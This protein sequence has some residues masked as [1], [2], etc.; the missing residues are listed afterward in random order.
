MPRG[1]ARG[2][3]DEQEVAFAVVREQHRHRPPC[4]PLLPRVVRRHRLCDAGGGA[5]C[6]VGHEAAPAE[7]SH[8]VHRA[9]GG[10]DGAQGR[11]GDPS[12]VLSE[13]VADSARG[14]SRRRRADLRARLAE[15]VKHLARGCDRGAPDGADRRAQSRLRALKVVAE[16]F[17]GGG[18]CARGCDADAER[19]VGGDSLRRPRDR[20]D[21]LDG[22]L[23][24]AAARPR[25]EGG[26]DAPPQDDDVRRVDAVRRARL[27]SARGGLLVG[28]GELDVG[29]EV[30]VE[31]GG[32]VA[33][34]H[35]EGELEAV[36]D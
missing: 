13:P 5:L 11:G 1:R 6:D 2:G 8:V 35:I 25:G 32:H 17:G 16:P 18:P 22:R 31:G 19:D 14:D 21:A 12:G 34:K 9:D 28:V 33:A 15:R 7:R 10:A 23:E 3:G 30:E 24:G 26:V 4:R 20:R 29:G 36:G 27:L